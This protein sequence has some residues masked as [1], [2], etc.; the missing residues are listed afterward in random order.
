M[1]ASK[2][3]RYTRGC[4]IEK[5]KAGETQCT[6]CPGCQKLAI[7]DCFKGA[8]N[9]ALP[10]DIVEVR[11]KYTHKAYFKTNG[12]V[13]RIGDVVAV[14]ATAGHDIG[15]VSLVGDLVYFQMLRNGL[16]PKDYEYKKVYRK[17]K[18]YDLE[19]WN[20]AILQEQSLMVRARKLA[21]ALKLNMKI[22]DVEMYGDRTKAIFY[23]IADERV[24]F[25]ELIKMMADEFKLRI[26]M[27]Q[28][29]ARQ[30]AGRIGSIAV[31]GRELC[32]SSFLSGFASVSTNTARDQD[33]STNPQK[34]AGQCGKLK[35][36]LN[37]ELS[38]YVDAQ[39]DFPRNYSSLETQ[40]GT[41]Y[42]HKTD[43]FKRMMW[44]NFDRTSQENLVAVPVDRVIE[45]LTANKKGEKV[46]SLLSEQYTPRERKPVEHDYKSAVGEDNIARFDKSKRKSGKR[47]KQDSR[48]RKPPR[49]PKQEQKLMEQR[50]KIRAQGQKNE[51]F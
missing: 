23:Y 39:K 14:E 32:C 38:A 33:F 41:A 50:A 30:E 1:M 17:A 26:E 15:T 48:H 19:K 46:A 44:Y 37:Y 49:D 3:M 42:H 10:E 2:E 36:C 25:R 8:H 5:T 12:L 34:L 16:N 21:V 43:I 47:H 31:C 29:G 9:A 20:D 6:Q 4:D 22:G 11:F 35:C 28:I 18:S 40:D 7:S 13:L 24:D 51:N 27:R 45:I